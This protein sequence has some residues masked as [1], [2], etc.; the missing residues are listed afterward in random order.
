MCD[1]DVVSQW[2]VNGRPPITCFFPARFQCITLDV[3]KQSFADAEDFQYKL[4]GKTDCL[5][6]LVTCELLTH[7]PVH[8]LE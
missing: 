7:F 3:G 6:D 1:E 2:R 8:V 5:S 4:K